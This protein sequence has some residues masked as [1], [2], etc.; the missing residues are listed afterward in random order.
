MADD[1]RKDMGRCELNDGGEC[2]ANIPEAC[3]CV[4]LRSLESFSRA[5]DAIFPDTKADAD[6]PA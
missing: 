3:V 6:K 1:W 5:F 4:E 2:I